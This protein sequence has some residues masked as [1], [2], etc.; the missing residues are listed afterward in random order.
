MESEAL[1]PSYALTLLVDDFVLDGSEDTDALTLVA[2]GIRDGTMLSMVTYRRSK[3][4]VQ[5]FYVQA[6]DHDMDMTL[7]GTYDVECLNHGR[8]VYKREGPPPDVYIYYWDDEQDLDWDTGLVEAGWWIGPEVGDRVWMYNAT[9]GVG[10][11]PPEFGWRVGYPPGGI[12]H[13]FAVVQTDT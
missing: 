2:A 4:L 7:E 10:T 5:A 13:A 6:M 9:K 1:L 11:Y 12:D 8:P 3:L